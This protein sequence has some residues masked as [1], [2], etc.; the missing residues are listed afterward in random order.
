MPT[1]PNGLYSSILSN[2]SIPSSRNSIKSRNLVLI[3]KDIIPVGSKNSTGA[4]S[5][6]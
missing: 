5:V 6:T 3:N 4:N 2:R 1:P